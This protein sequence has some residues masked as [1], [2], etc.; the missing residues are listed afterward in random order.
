[1]VLGD[2]ADRV[3]DGCTGGVPRDAINRVFTTCVG[4][5]R[6]FTTCVGVGRVFTTCVG[7]GRVFTTRAGVGRVVM[8]GIGTIDDDDAVDVIGHDDKGV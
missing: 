1:M 6:V 3:V 2:A 5:D 8:G 4:V 7:I